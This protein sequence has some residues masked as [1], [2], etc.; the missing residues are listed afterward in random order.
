MISKAARADD[1]I[2]H[3]SDKPSFSNMGGSSKPS[4]SAWIVSITSLTGFNSVH[5]YGAPQL[6]QLFGTGTGGAETTP[7]LMKRPRISTAHG[8]FAGS[9]ETTLVTM[10]LAELWRLVITRCY[11]VALHADLLSIIIGVLSAGQST[12]EHV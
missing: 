6:W 11:L 9:L 12:S 4:L 3:P 1:A 7:G 10:I 2:R 8:A 5:G